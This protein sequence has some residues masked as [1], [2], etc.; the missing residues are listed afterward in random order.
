MRTGIK[1]DSPLW[2]YVYA[3]RRDGCPRRE[4]R[5]MVVAAMDLTPAQKWDFNMTAARSRYARGVHRVSR[6]LPPTPA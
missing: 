6:G 3:L 2:E 5:Q 1:R 4:R